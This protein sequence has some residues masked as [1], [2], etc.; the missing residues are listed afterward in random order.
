LVGSEEEF[1]EG[2]VRWWML[3]K[4]GEREGRERT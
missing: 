4:D 3:V 1:D 2:E